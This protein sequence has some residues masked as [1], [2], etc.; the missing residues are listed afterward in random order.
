MSAGSYNHTQV[1]A[2]CKMTAI[3]RPK[4]LADRMLEGQARSW[5]AAVLRP[6]A[7]RGISESWKRLASTLLG[8]SSIQLDTQPDQGPIPWDCASRPP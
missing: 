2:R 5:R 8:W 3:I 7:D 4:K 6:S 1:V